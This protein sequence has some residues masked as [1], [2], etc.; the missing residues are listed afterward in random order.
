MNAKVIVAWIL[1]AVLMGC[2]GAPAHSGT[3]QRLRVVDEDGRPVPGA[4][5]RLFGEERMIRLLGNATTD[6]DGVARFVNAPSGGYAVEAA[7]PPRWNIETDEMRGRSVWLA[8]ELVT[9]TVHELRM[10]GVRLPGGRLIGSSAGSWHGHDP[11][12]LDL[13]RELPGWPADALVLHAFRRPSTSRDAIAMDFVAEWFGYAPLVER[14]TWTPASKFTGPRVVDRAELAAIPWRE[15]PVVLRDPD[16]TA[17]PAETMRA[18]RRQCVLFR[19]DDD[20][21]HRRYQLD[22]LAARKDRVAAPCGEYMLRLLQA[23]PWRE[24]PLTI[25]EDTTVID[26]RLPLRLRLLRLRLYGVVGT[27]WS[28]RAEGAAHFDSLRLSTANC[29]LEIPL[30]V[31]ESVLEF[32]NHHEGN[33]YQRRTLPVVVR[34]EDVQEIAWHV[35]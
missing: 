30:P 6:R 12:P 15:L 27:N 13:V 8:E 1:V 7:A 23:G 28:V 11:A 16:G 29:V 24:V 4:H 17:L 22:P 33:G 26:C 2:T 18:V 19:R 5:V 25:G 20:Q 35:R 32:A 3:D 14:Q 34:D 9:V 31:G 21:F 10:V